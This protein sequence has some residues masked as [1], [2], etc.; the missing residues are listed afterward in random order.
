MKV[1]QLNVRYSE[2]GAAGVAFTL[3]DELLA[4]GVLSC[5]AYGYG[6]HGRGSESGRADP[7]AT[8][9]ANFGT[10]LANI[11]TFGLTGRDRFYG[12]SARVKLRRLIAW[13]DIV[14]LHVVHSYFIPLDVLVDELC[15]GSKPVV[16]T[17]H[18]EWAVTGRCA[19]PGTCEVWQQG[20]VKCPDL[21]AYPP[22]RVDRAATNFEWKRS[23]IARLASKTALAIVPCAEWLGEVV[24]SS[25]IRIDRVISNS[26]DRSFWDEA[27]R[28]QQVHSAGFEFS[29]RGAAAPTSV[30]FICRDLRDRR[31]VDWEL[32][33]LVDQNPDLH[34]TVVGSNLPDGELAGSTIIPATTSRAEIARVLQRN[35]KLLFSSEVDYF[36][37]TIIEALVSGCEV[38]ASNSRASRELSA[39]GTV[40]LYG[41]RQE[42]IDILH[43][44][45]GDAGI[46]RQFAPDVMAANYIELY[47]EILG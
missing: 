38:V 39:L 2:G 7:Y 8:E 30:A 4:Q 44:K 32:L 22:A 33:R 40:T 27:L 12:P 24:S 25:G 41:N 26:V 19:Q 10:V 16:W 45:A 29:D 3:H 11:S 36:P 5:F 9:L 35:E 14:H 21:N 6:P 23:Q 28:L 42:A 37:L 43:S 46:D 20:C 18:D 1:L 34:L 15:A 13:A 31:K 17:L 47:K